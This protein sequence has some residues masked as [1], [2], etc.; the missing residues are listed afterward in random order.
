MQ[1]IKESLIEVRKA[2]R[3][4]FDFQSRILDLISYI[5]EK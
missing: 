1:E 2:Y 3:L 4:I 5:K